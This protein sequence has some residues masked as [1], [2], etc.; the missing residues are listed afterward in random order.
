MVA[1]PKCPFGFSRAYA[2]FAVVAMLALA[3][4]GVG[5][6]FTGRGNKVPS[7][8]NVPV[9]LSSANAIAVMAWS[10]RDLVTLDDP[11]TANITSPTE[12]QCFLEGADV[13]V[14][15]SVADDSPGDLSSCQVFLDGGLVDTQSPCPQGDHSFGPFSP[16][17]GHHTVQIFVTD[18]AGNNGSSAVVHFT[19]DS[20]KPTATINSPKNSD[21][22]PD[23]GVTIDY[24]VAD[25]LTGDLAKC[26]V[27]IDTVVV[28]TMAPCPQ[29]NHTSGPHT[30]TDGTH[31]V[32]IRVT[33]ACGNVGTSA[34]IVFT[35]DTTA[36]TASINSPKEGDCVFV[37]ED[38][39]DDLIIF[40]TVADNLPGSLKKCEILI[41]G[42]VVFVDSSCPQGLHDNG[43][44]F[45]L[46]GP[47]TVQIRVTDNCD[48][49]GMSALV[50]F[51]VDSTPPTVFITAPRQN[52]CVGGPVTIKFNVTDTPLT[53]LK[54]C[55]I[56]IDGVVKD[57]FAP[58]AQGDHTAGPYTL[59]DGPHN[60][61][62][63]AM[64]NCDNIGFSD[65]IQFTVDATAPTATITSPKE[66]DCS[67][68]S[69][70][71]VSYTVDDNIHDDLN[72]CEVLVDGVVKTTQSPC[73]RGFHTSGPYTLADG[74]HTFQIRVRDDCGNVG[75][76]TIINFKVDTAKPTVSITSPTEGACMDGTNA[77]ISYAA[78]D[79]LPGDLQK[80]E[81]TIDGTLKETKS[82]CPQGDEIA[83]P[84]SLTDGPHTVQIRVTDDCGN[85]G[86]SVLVHFTV[87]NSPPTCSIQFPKN[88][89][90][91]AG[92]VTVKFTIGDNV[93][94]NISWSILADGG[95]VEHNEDSPQGPQT[96]TPIFLPLG[97]HQIS[98]VVHDA[99]GNETTCGPLTVTISDGGCVG[100]LLPNLIVGPSAAKDPFSGGPVRV[101]R[102]ATL[103][104][105]TLTL[106]DV[107]IGNNVT[108]DQNLIVQDVRVSKLTSALKCTVFG[109][110]PGSGYNTNFNS[111]LVAASS[112]SLDVSVCLIALHRAIDER[113]LGDRCLL[114]SPPCTTYTLSVVYVVRDPKTGRTG[115][116]ITSS[117]SWV[118]K[119]PT[120]QDIRDNIEYFGTVAAGFTQKCKIDDSV[121]EAL[122]AALDNPND[123]EALLEFETVI[124]FAA[125][126][127]QTLRDA[128]DAK[129]NFDARLL[130]D[131]LIDSDEEPIGCLL[132]EMANFALWN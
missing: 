33:D 73:S 4:V 22:L 110:G 85:V 26:E 88:G 38:D 65:T 45:P 20:T 31:K 32:Q 81:I 114:F 74:L 101:F 12:G 43:G 15:Y 52:D 5:Q 107:L 68:N 115:S 34:L 111:G 2:L 80:C 108:I 41:D 10:S 36:P 19:L 16:A 30:L 1:I 35:V 29:G 116:P 78:A 75:T 125:T 128:K 7:Q 120:R 112:A 66:G 42:F 14:S 98:V 51:T 103:N 131:Y 69:S 71:S 86:Q 102:P 97:P 44:F 40:Y 109:S 129:G 122:N 90:T 96:S 39:D 105:D 54:N 18:A 25:N 130:H 118:I 62:V 126:D 83:G 87:D 77:M 132:I 72:R 17:N 123:L 13:T 84:F 70:L 104:I 94:G 48:N 28:D 59:P 124:A 92:P 82:P 23:S 119:N 27:L 3:P 79:N 91:I 56:R 55:E 93:P 99:C 8:L 100:T 21:C 64:D 53:D 46:D 63:T 11:P 127:F 121:M 6:P 61:R 113:C 49:V 60:V 67:K 57:T 106:R 95:V 24:K 9:G 37:S 50:N 47:H 76:S 58:C 117:L 89:D